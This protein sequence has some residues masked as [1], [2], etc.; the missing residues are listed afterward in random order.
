MSRRPASADEPRRQAAGTVV[1]WEEG[2]HSAEE[3]PMLKRLLARWPRTLRPALPEGF[4]VQVRLRKGDKI[5]RR[6]AHGHVQIVR[7]T[8]ESVVMGSK[9]TED[10][11]AGL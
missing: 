8:V 9:K 3:A 4:G 10:R 2:A 1:H 11:G 6:D 7:V 5:V